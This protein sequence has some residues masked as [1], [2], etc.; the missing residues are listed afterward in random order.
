M[1]SIYVVDYKMAGSNINL[2]LGWKLLREGLHIEPEQRANETTVLV[3]WDVDIL[4][5]LLSYRMVEWPPLR[6]MTWRTS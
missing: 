2:P 5:L 1:L 4:F 3:T 6:R